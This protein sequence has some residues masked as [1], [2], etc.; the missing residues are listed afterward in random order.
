MPR[1][2]GLAGLA[3]RSGSLM[4]GLLEQLAHGDTERP[5]DRRE[6]CPTYVGSY[7]LRASDH[8]VIQPGPRGY[9]RQAEPAA[10]SRSLDALHR[11]SPI[12]AQTSSGI[13]SSAFLA[14]GGSHGPGDQCSE[15]ALTEAESSP[16][17][18][19]LHHGEAALVGPLIQGGG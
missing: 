9:G 14:E 11:L 13:Q 18:E 5:R 4:A 10:L 7:P 6:R 17:P 15:V 12:V 16:G 2:W 8:L 1:W 3:L 19:Q